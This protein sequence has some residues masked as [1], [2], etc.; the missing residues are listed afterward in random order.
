MSKKLFCL[1]VA[2][3]VI[4][5]ICLSAYLASAAPPQGKGNDRVLSKVKFIHYRQGYGKPEGTPGGGKAKDK[6]EGY[7]TYLAK[8]AKWKE[9]E[10]Y[11]LNSSNE[12]DVAH[13]GVCEAVTQG[14]GQWAFYASFE[15]FGAVLTDEPVNYDEGDYR[16][17][18]TISFGSHDNSNVIAEASVWGY[19]GGPPSQREIVEAHILLND[20]GFDWGI[21]T[22][23][24]DSFMD[25]QNIVTHELG[26]CAGMG[27]LYKTE[28]IDE[29]MFGF[30]D[31]GETN[32]RD[33]YFG[34]IAGI[35]ELYK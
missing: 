2:I 8:G 3:V 16:G 30:S 7:Y 20:A 13:E 12:D 28:A 29:T 6:D 23:H 14:M 10:P 15:I 32:K 17:Y 9:T 1:A 11:Y 4:G 24:E 25:V 26:H 18:N 35:A 22:N 34:D 19:F 5:T 33:L 31:E 21:V 27:D